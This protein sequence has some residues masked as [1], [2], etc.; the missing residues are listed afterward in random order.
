VFLHRSGPRIGARPE[1]N[2]NAHH[3]KPVTPT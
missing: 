3:G 2:K 1:V